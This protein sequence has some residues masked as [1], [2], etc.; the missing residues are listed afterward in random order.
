[1]YYLCDNMKR[2]I[3]KNWTC[4]LLTSGAEKLGVH[5]T[6]E[7]F[8]SS[9]SILM[10]LPKSV[11]FTVRPSLNTNIFLPTCMDVCIYEHICM[12]V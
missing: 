4:C 9:A 7:L 12:Y 10:A 5:P 6:R 3:G 8:T 2:I 1:M 11:S